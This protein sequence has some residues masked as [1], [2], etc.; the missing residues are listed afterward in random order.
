MSRKEH[1]EDHVNHEAWA[2]PYGD[3]ITLLLAFFV[4]MYAVSSVNEG[5]YRV[6]SDS[7]NAAFRGQ[8]HTLDPIQVGDKETRVK[9]DTSPAG[10]SPSQAMKL[11]AKPDKAIAALAEEFGK[12]GRDIDRQ[13]PAAE[14]N[15]A[16]PARSL[17][18]QFEEAMAPL[19][20]KELVTVTRKPLWVE[21]EIKADV[22]FPSGSAEIQPAALPALESIATILRPLPC[23]VRIEGHTDNRPISTPQFPSNWE[24]SGARASRIVR[25][26]EKLGVASNRMSVAGQGEY[27]PIADNSTDEGRN[28]NRRVTLIVLDAQPGAESPAVPSGLSV[29]ASTPDGGAT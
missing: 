10:L 25:L 18:R 26:F 29:P 1:H 17:D 20:G 13:S 22:L 24:L 15:S 5:K 11:A 16:L 21:I 4:V 14:Q 19:I 23:P 28:R 8:P 2:I 9:R 27:Q 6:L 7:L 3:L 12:M